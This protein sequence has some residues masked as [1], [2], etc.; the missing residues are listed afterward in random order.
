MNYRIIAAII[1]TVALSA[2]E[3]RTFPAKSLEC[4]FGSQEVVI[5]PV[6]NPHTGDGKLIYWYEGVNK[7]I[8]P[9][10]DCRVVDPINP[11]PSKTFYNGAEIKGK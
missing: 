9:S 6:Y 7:S 1:A 3:E 2:C 11:I 8:Y 5:T 10:S 4:R